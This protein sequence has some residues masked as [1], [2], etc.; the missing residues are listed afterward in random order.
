M[1][2]PSHAEETELSRMLYH[3]AETRLQYVRTA[4]EAAAPAL[5]IAAESLLATCLAGQRV[6]LCPQPGT[7]AL[8]EHTASLLL[9]GMVQPRPGLPV[10]LLR[11]LPEEGAVC[12][13]QIGSLAAPG[14]TLLAFNGPRTDGLKGLI[15]T[16][17]LHDMRLILLGG[18]VSKEVASHLQENDLVIQLDTPCPT[19]LHEAALAAVHTL[20]DA[21]D[22]RLLGL[23]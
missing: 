6:Y 9:R 17:R 18:P 10:V 11:P 23:A 7:E 1:P 14:D 4:L 5:A 21:L 19:S 22:H 2:I 16:A 20:C 12:M 13:Q 3:H 8:A 15:D